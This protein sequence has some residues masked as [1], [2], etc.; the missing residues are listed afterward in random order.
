V[1]EVTALTPFPLIAIEDLATSDLD[2]GA[3]ERGYG[4]P[5]MVDL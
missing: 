4:R 1:I 5:K 3:M 2:R